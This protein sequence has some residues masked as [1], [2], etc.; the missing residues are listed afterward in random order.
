MP[1]DVLR[2]EGAVAAPKPFVLKWAEETPPEWL[3]SERAVFSGPVNG[4][5]VSLA[6]EPDHVETTGPRDTADSTHT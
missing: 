1:A 6:A 4:L 2:G 5:D 3:W